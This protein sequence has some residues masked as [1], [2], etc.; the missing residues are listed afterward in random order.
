MKNSECLIIL[1]IVTLV[2]LSAVLFGALVGC[3]EQALEQVDQFVQDVNTVKT[4]TEAVLKSPAG[5][6][7]P[8]HWKLYGSLAAL[9]ASGLINAWQGWRNDTMKKTTKAIVKGIEKSNN[10]EKPTAEVKSNIAD[11]MLKQGGEK[12]YDKANRIVDRLK[13]A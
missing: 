13:I 12:F 6:M 8:P 11:E 2:T 5:A 3:D 9:L 1:F 4:G 10:P 7:L